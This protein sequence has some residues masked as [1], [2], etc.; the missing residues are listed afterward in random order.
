VEKN[1]GPALVAAEPGRCCLPCRTS[2]VSAP[3]HKVCPDPAAALFDAGQGI[4]R[5]ATHN[6]VPLGSSARQF[7]PVC[8]GDPIGGTRLGEQVLGPAPP[9]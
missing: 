1:T 5:Y 8:R 7:S 2:V 9:G 6:D 4:S 3:G